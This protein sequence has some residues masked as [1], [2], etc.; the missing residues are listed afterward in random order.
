[1]LFVA[2]ITVP[3]EEDDESVVD[4]EERIEV[5]EVEEESFETGGGTLG[6]FEV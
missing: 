1:M 4:G 3:V 2:R 5:L 6:V